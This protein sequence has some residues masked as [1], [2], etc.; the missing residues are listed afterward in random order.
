MGRKIGGVIVGYIVMAAFIFIS[1][2]VLYLILGPEGSFEPG[3]YMVSTAWLVL[4]FVLGLIA[5]VIGGYVCMLIAKS[6]ETVYVFAGI[7]LLLG[8]I[9]AIPSLNI[10]DEELNRPREGEVSN[11]EAM[12]DAKQP[13]IALILNPLIGAF[14]V[15]IGGRMKKEKLPDVQ[16]RA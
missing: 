6:Q 13:P 10:P 7:V 8:L 4:S 5:A 15:L 16:Q 3:S 2:T 14:G 1:F 12:Q 11:M 9:L